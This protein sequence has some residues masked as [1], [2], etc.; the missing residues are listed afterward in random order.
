M[1]NTS[2]KSK[3]KAQFV[4]LRGDFDDSPE[5]V[6][7]AG[8]FPTLKAAQKF[9]TDEYLADNRDEYADD[10]EET[11]VECPKFKDFLE[12]GHM[13]WRIATV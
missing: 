11:D 2:S 13:F 6:E 1:K 5:D 4:V 8:I 9:V 7:V 12:G 3:T 10:D